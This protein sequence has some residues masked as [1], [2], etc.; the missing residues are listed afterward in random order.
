MEEL[1]KL[2]WQDTVPAG[3]N[4]YHDREQARP[5]RERYLLAYIWHRSGVD[6]DDPVHN[7]FW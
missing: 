4:N 7:T 1:G 5:G 3:E 6:Q 2:F